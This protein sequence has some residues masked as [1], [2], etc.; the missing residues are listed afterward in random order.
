MA[1]SLFNRAGCLRTGLIVVMLVI[2]VSMAGLYWF[3]N[4]GLYEGKELSEKYLFIKN[5][6]I[7]KGLSDSILN[8]NILVKNGEILCVGDCEMPEDAEVLDAK[9]KAIIPGLTDMM[10]QFY[11]PS[12]EDR[13]LSGVEQLLSFTQ[14][15]P[16]VRKNFHLAG[17]TNI[18]SVGD[19]LGNI[20]TLRKQ[21]NEQQLAGPRIFCTGLMFTATGGFPLASLYQGNDFMVKEG[22]RTAD[23][24]NV[25]RPKI[26]EVIASGVDGI[27]IVYHDFGGRFNRISKDVL[28]ELVQ[29]AKN[30]NKWVSVH[31]GTSQEIVEAVN[32][33]AN[34]LEYGS[35]EPLDSLA[36]QAMLDHQV[37]YIPALV[38]F[39][40]DSQ[41]LSIAKENVLKAWQA[42]VPMGV[43]AD[44]Q[45]YL[46]F[47]RSL[48]REMELL[49]EAGLNPFYVLK[50][51]TWLAAT[52]LKKDDL[53]GA[54]TPDRLADLVIVDG[55]P[56]ESIS[57]IKNVYT[58]IQEGRIVVLQK[59]IVE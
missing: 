22:I 4:S 39:E 17:L 28:N 11:A 12:G 42:G 7:F 43:G 31:T 2:S 44:A 33:G 8:G 20:I 52:Y 40:S 36:I 18:R 26:R 48:H 49:V 46:P 58:V 14:Q 56:W 32:A 57:D 19:A 10:V 23:D 34:T 59:Q 1:E 55:T 6:R 29:S 21:I 5:G 47:G 16:E 27:K 38:R 9:G 45:D 30:A 54:I 35:Y 53:M 3:Y 37:M 24:V 13:K 51:A 41:K 50:S 25:A 15:R